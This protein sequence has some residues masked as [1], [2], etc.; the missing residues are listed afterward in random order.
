VQAITLCFAT[1]QGF[2]WRKVPYYILA[3]IFGAFMAALILVG[4]YH[5]QFTLMEQE[6]EAAGQSIIGPAT[7]AGILAPLPQSYQNNQGW[8]FLIEF[9]VC[10]FIVMFRCVFVRIVC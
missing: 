8:L 7:P 9:F 6:L 5:E 1:W 4:Q 3:Q 10:T 2:P